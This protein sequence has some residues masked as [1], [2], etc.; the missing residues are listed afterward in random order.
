MNGATPGT[1]V[2]ASVPNL[3]LTPAPYWIVVQETPADNWYDEHPV[4]FDPNISDI[5]SAFFG[6]APP[7][8]G[9]QINTGNV[10]TSYSAPYVGFH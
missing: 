10:N 8:N 6:G 5:V 3:F 2:K 9:T 4:T 1:Y 7:T